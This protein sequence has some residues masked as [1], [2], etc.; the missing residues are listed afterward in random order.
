MN[1]RF[2]A[3]PVPLLILFLFFSMVFASEKTEIQYSSKKAIFNSKDSLI[4]LIDSA[5]IE[6]DAIK[7][8]A[9]TI[10]YY[11]D[12]RIL[13]AVGSPLLLQNG[14]SLRGEY[15]AY[16]LDT[17]SG[18]IKSGNYETSDN[19]HYNGK[20]IVYHSDSSI[21]IDEGHYTS[22]DLNP[23]NYTFYAEK[24]KLI[25]EDKGIAKP[26][27]LE[28]AKSPVLALPFFVT[29]L[30]KK[31]KSG[32]LIPR[33]G[34][35]I[36]GSGN[37]D[38]IG[39]YWYIN[40]YLDFRT[41]GKIDN[42]SKF[43]LKAESNYR[44]KNKLNG[45]I[46]SD[47]SLN[48]KYQGR[49]NRWSLKYSHFQQLL[50]DKSFQL[51]GSGNLISDNKFFEDNSEDTT[52]LLSKQVNSNLSLN[53][54]FKQLGGS[55]RLSWSRS[56]NLSEKTITQTLPDFS[57]RL[58]SR[59]LIPTP[60]SITKKS[61]SEDEEDEKWYE[62]I[63][64]SYSFNAKQSL[65]KNYSDTSSDTT[66]N[67]VAGAYHTL[68]IQ[69][70]FTLFDYITITPNFTVSQSI[71]D[72]YSDTTTKDTFYD[73]TYYY[74]DTLSYE[75]TQDLDNINKS[76]DT[77]F[78]KDTTLFLYMKKESIKQR[79]VID[80]TQWGDHD[81]ELN[82]AANTWWNT[83][84][85]LST[86]L[87]GTFP[88]KIGAFQGLRHTMSP[89]LRYTFTPKKELKY[90]YPTVVSSTRGTDQRQDLSFSL[91][92]SFHGKIKKKDKKGDISEKELALLT[93][94][95]SASYNFEAD[96]SRWSNIN[97]SA[98]VPNNFVNFSYR[99]SLT[100]YDNAHQLIFP[101]A[102]SHSIT[103]TPRVPSISGNIWSGDFFTLEKAAYD[104]YLGDL[105]KNKPTWQLSLSPSFNFKLNRKDINESFSKTE[106]YNL[107][108]SIK[109]QFTN[110]WHLSWGGN[111]SFT[112]NTFINQ[113]IS[114]FADLNSWDLKFDWYPTG[115][116]S[117]RFYFIVAIKKHREIKWEQK[118]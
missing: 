96:T 65:K 117:G 59:Q 95:I 81:F 51:S 12:K 13:I 39:Y 11:T 27:I 64:W 25:P 44:V 80:T 19:L 22:C 4:T 5:Y 107:R 24:F 87:Y 85:S 91:G 2:R 89:S 37:I 9:D 1:S 35:G 57:F 93:A 101:K 92:N 90:V 41:M 30:D 118:S 31:S 45:R 104:G 83:G 111:W 105:H 94:N 10:D 53:K 114:L 33:W 52:E 49:E 88:I 18:K 56:Q 98:S 108:S 63:T 74:E 103:A 77:L 75:Q 109:L 38:N 84:V 72:R 42:F 76:F 60:K 116:N 29:P 97:L 79:I 21:Y 26:F 67:S 54:T 43:M 110:R 20:R 28:I 99:S 82:K 8:F 106:N 78:L 70:K 6:Y 112:E 36:N 50:P 34:V 23:P 58:N 46:Y 69:A 62:A 15:I 47:F 68:P 61:T 100:P 16:N 7:L 3:M 71:F 48:D 73:T 14:D 86:K 66:T 113:N 55:S 40:D 32:W 102:L 115:V 17:K